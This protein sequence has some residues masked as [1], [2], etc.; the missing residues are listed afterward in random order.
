MP[1]LSMCGAFWFMY[2][3]NSVRKEI[4]WALYLMGDAWKKGKEDRK[5]FLHFNA[6][7]VWKE[8]ELGVADGGG[9][10]EWQHVEDRRTPR[11]SR[12]R[13]DGDWGS[14]RKR[15]VDKYSAKWQ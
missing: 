9:G 12:K 3:E 7:G 2:L 14:N 13:K 5:S 4:S 6:S 1:T 15:S 8:E 11:R 10:W